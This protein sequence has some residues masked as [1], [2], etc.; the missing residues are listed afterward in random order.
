MEQAEKTEMQVVQKMIGWKRIIQRKRKK[1]KSLDFEQN[2]QKQDV[3]VG[4]PEMAHSVHNTV[5]STLQDKW[6][7]HS[8]FEPIWSL[9]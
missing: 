6:Y 1:W 4:R 8:I 2:R 5:Y 7:L 3:Q 9:N